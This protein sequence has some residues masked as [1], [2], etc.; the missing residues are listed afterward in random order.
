MSLLSL[1]LSLSRSL[2]FCLSVC[3]SLSL[4]LCLSVSLALSRARSLSHTHMGMRPRRS[5]PERRGSTLKRSSDFQ[6]PDSGP[7]CLACAEFA[8]QRALGTV[9]EAQVPDDSAAPEE[10]P[11]VY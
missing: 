2:S 3:F 1:S 10:F 9:L 11:L 8:R 5:A 7:D 4:S 6:L